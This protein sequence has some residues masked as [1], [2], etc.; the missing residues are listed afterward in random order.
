MYNCLLTDCF[1]EKIV[2]KKF[3]GPHDPSRSRRLQ[4][5]SPSQFQCPRRPHL[6]SAVFMHDPLTLT[7]AYGAQPVQTQSCLLMRWGSKVRSK[8]CLKHCV[9]CMF[10]QGWQCNVSHSISR[11]AVYFIIWPSVPRIICSNVR[12]HIHTFL[13]T[14]LSSCPL[15]DHDSSLFCMSQHH[16]Y[17]FVVI[18]LS[19]S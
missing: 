6:W 19:T 7:I 15:D 16:S 14:G 9:Q 5:I 18:A 3:A 12:G 4:S 2:M 11:F 13:F 17:V 1:S 10:R 8:S